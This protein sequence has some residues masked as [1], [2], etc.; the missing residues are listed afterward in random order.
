MVEDKCGCQWMSAV[1]YAPFDFTLCVYTWG[2][3]RNDRFIYGV[4]TY[5]YGWMPSVTV[6]YGLLV[7][8]AF[9]NFFKIWTRILRTHGMRYGEFRTPDAIQTITDRTDRYGRTIRSIRR[10]RI[11]V[12]DLGIRISH[13]CT[14]YAT[15][16]IRWRWICMDLIADFLR[17]NAGW[18]HGLIV[19]SS[20]NLLVRKASA[21]ARPWSSR[22]ST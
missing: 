7:R 15:W 18:L 12:S 16:S 1:R 2:V 8:A 22:R 4:D 17:V 3:P 6:H 13:Y 10:I 14:S 9:W 11:C 21:A 20:I 19:S 5:K